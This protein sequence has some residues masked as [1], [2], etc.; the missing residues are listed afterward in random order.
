[1]KFLLSPSKTQKMRNCS[2]K[3]FEPLMKD[4]TKHV[5]D[6]VLQL[7]PQAY[8]KATKQD[9]LKAS[10]MLTNMKDTTEYGIAIE[11]YSGLV[12][13]QLQL[14]SYTHEQLQFL[15]DNVMILSARYGML[16]ANDY[17]SPYRLDFTMKFSDISLMKHWQFHIKD[18]LSNSNV[19]E[20]Y[21]S[22]ASKE[23]NSLFSEEDIVVIDFV[24]NSQGVHKR[25]STMMKQIRGQFL[26]AVILNK[27]DTI[28]ALLALEVN[29][30][31]YQADQSTKYVLVFQKN[32]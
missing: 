7:S 15:Y 11:S 30:F 22:L 1:M 5:Q 14:D 12:F 31:T 17:I 25:Q 24:V 6:F 2:T 28:D 16:R 23:F 29:G 13:K 26:N 9:L 19:T 10:T 27:I 8:A 21:I 20:P 4:H 18:Y 3:G 32:E